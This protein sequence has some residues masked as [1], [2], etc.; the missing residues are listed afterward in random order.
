MSLSKEVEELQKERSLLTNILQSIEK[1]EEYLR[2]RLGVLGENLAIQELKMK[3][4]ARRA[5]VEQLKSKVSDL[6]KRLTE[7]QK[8]LDVPPS[9]QPQVS[10]KAEKPE[11]E[12]P[13][14]VIV[15]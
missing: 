2:K 4:K 5:I 8:Q 14:R 10:E 1:E 11:N 13:V 12:K 3:I 9:P 15:S 7:S 6:E